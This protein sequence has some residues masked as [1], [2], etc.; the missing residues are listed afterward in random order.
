[1]AF[2]QAMELIYES[3]TYM[4]NHGTWQ[5]EAARSAP[6]AGVILGAAGFAVRRRPAR[7]LERIR[8]I[9]RR[10]RLHGHKRIKYI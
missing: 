5:G 8:G 1:M 4:P 3:Y 9:W 2:D 7:P 10:L 6:L